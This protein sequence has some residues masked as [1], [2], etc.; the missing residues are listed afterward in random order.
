MPASIKR[1]FYMFLLLLAA[2]LLVLFQALQLPAEHSNLRDFDDLE[3]ELLKPKLYGWRETFEN[4]SMTTTPPLFVGPVPSVCLG[5]STRC[6]EGLL[7]LSPRRTQKSATGND[8]KRTIPA[9]LHLVSLNEQHNWSDFDDLIR[10]WHRLHRGWIYVL[11][12]KI[13]YRKL[14]RIFFPRYLSVIEDMSNSTNSTLLA[15]MLILQK[16][17]GV[18]IGAP[19][20][21]AIRNIDSIRWLPAVFVT[22]SEFRPPNKARLIDQTV[23]MAA[24]SHPFVQYCTDQVLHHRPAQKS[25]LNLTELLPK[26]ASAFPSTHRP[27]HSV[28]LARPSRTSTLSFSGTGNSASLSN[29]TMIDGIKYHLKKLHKIL[30]QCEHS[31]GLHSKF[32]ANAAASPATRMTCSELLHIRSFLEGEDTFFALG[33]PETDSLSISE[34]RAETIKQLTSKYPLLNVG[35]QRAWR[36]L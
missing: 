15:R 25:L 10:N 26:Y 19:K 35:L 1:S 18:V 27:E 16:F 3:N 5:S 8:D 33:T 14:V 6:L 12:T 20:L 30:R 4:A 9:I 36:G 23:F 13:E 22:S 2:C 34:H 31:A 11:W 7:L 24:P 29:Y 28:H 32:N 21:R 17:G